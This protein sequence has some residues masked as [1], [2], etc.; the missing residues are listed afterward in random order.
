MS[1]DAFKLHIICR[2]ALPN[3]IKFVSPDFEHLK[4]WNVRS[5]SSS[6]R[7]FKWQIFA[8]LS[9]CPI[10]IF[11]TN[12]AK[13]VDFV[14]EFCLFSF[15]FTSGWPSFVLETDNLSRNGL[16]EK[17]VSTPTVPFTDTDL[18][19]SCISFSLSLFF[20]Y[21]FLPVQ[22]LTKKAKKKR[23]GIEA[24]IRSS[25]QWRER[26]RKKRRTAA[27]G[28]KGGERDATLSFSLSPHSSCVTW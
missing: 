9:I 24:S 2:S 12:F 3:Y 6:E 27:W 17:L 21:F 25:I 23:E 5:A 11:F 1:I 22:F 7:Q 8:L 19:S 13:R 10:F 20:P 16:S 15:L 18:L 14:V 28:E 26:E 4:L